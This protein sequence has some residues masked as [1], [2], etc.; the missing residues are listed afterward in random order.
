[1]SATTEH[2]TPLLIGVG[3]AMRSDDGVGIYVARQIAAA[4][5][6]GRIVEASGEGAALME[7]WRGADHVIIVDAVRSGATPGT[8]HRLDAAAG[9]LPSEFFNYST[10]AFS[11]AEAVELARVLGGLP[12]HL[13]IVGIEGAQFDYGTSLTPAI[14]EAADTIIHELIDLLHPTTHAAN[15]R[16]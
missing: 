2:S 10:H 3:N 4:Q 7:A 6:D 9:S 13:L 11:V 15:G 1:M 14:Q 16:P 5:H 12:E 8:I